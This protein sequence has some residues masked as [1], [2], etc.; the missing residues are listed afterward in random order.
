MRVVILAAFLLAFVAGAHG[1][2]M[3]WA[4]PGVNSC[5]VYAQD[6][7][8]FPADMGNFYF[9]WAQGFMSGLNSGHYRSRGDTSGDT[10]LASKSF[11][12]QAQED[13]IRRY[14]DQHLLASFV[15]AVFALWAEMRRLQGLPPD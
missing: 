1:Q 4:G 5:A 14:C 12:N 10:D 9:F 15:D 2:P 11:P 7:K 13:F 6:Y 8:H 3:G